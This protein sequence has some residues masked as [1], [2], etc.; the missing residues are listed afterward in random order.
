MLGYVG[1]SCLG[2]GICHSD[3]EGWLGDF[4]ELIMMSSLKLPQRKLQQLQEKETPCTEA[5]VE[6]IVLRNIQVRPCLSPSRA[7]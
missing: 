5:Q 7:A 3:V 2:L 4:L 6:L 1:H